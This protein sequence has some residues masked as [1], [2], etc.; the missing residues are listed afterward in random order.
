[1]WWMGYNDAA[2]TGNSDQKTYRDFDWSIWLSLL[3]VVDFFHT[4]G[5]YSWMEIHPLFFSFYIFIKH[6]DLLS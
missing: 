5:L 1:M 4:H 6:T 3:K 2:E